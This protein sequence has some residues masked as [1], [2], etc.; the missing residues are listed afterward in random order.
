MDDLDGTK[1]DRDTSQAILDLSELPL[2]QVLDAGDSV[3][4]NA[5]RR[6]KEQLSRPGEH[7]A[8]HGTTL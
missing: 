3:L 2:D 1:S 6:V 4:D 5:L 8:A 7:Y